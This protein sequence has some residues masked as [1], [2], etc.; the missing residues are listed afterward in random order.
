[1]TGTITDRQSTASIHERSWIVRH[2]LAAYFFFAFAGTWLAI[3]PLVLSAGLNLFPLPEAASILLFFISPYVGPLLS[4]FVVTRVVEGPPAVR[5]LLKRIVQ[6]RVGFVWYLAALFSALIVWLAAYSLLYQG[7][8]LREFA[9]N[10]PL[11]FSFFFPNVLIG[12]FVPS[13]GE[14]TGWRGFALPRLQ[15]GYGPVMGT[16]ILGSLHSLWHLP[17][18]FTPFLGPFTPGRFIAFVI[19]GTAGSFIFTWIYNGGRGSV[20]IAIITHASFNASSAY[21]SRIIPQDIPLPAWVQPLVP[22][23]INAIAFVAA[24]GLLILVTRGR[25]GYRKDESAIRNPKPAV[26]SP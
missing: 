4:A 8:P 12:L 9:A 3:I 24:A 16:L 10:L 6:W 19:A 21:L 1:M 14:E 11:F 15:A 22:D 13:L 5:A 23:W 20:L 18:F 25:L 7:I 17:A 2:P 26:P